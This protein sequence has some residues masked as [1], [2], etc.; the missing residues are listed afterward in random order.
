[1][2]KTPSKNA[3]SEAAA[4]LAR[5]RAESLTAKER[6]DIAKRGAK[7][8]WGTDAQHEAVRKFVDDEVTVRHREG[9]ETQELCRVTSD[10]FA[11]YDVD[12]IPRILRQWKL[13]ERIRASR[14]EPV[15]ITRDGIKALD[16][17]AAKGTYRVRRE[18]T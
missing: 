2:S 10:F 8:R 4:A 6:R 3:A 17:E 12:D 16:P 15:L 18:Q 11:A 9:R 1:M 14:T 13:P 5:L 7:G